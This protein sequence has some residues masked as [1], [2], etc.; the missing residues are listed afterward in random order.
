MFRRLGRAAGI[1]I[2]LAATLAACD[3]S[4]PP[5]PASCQSS[6]VA[7]E[8]A[9]AAAPGPVRLAGGTPISTCVARARTD[10]QL[11]QVGSLLSVT[12]DQLAAR[13]VTD[14]AAALELGY[15]VGATRRGADRTNGV[16]SQLRQRIETAAA[17][18]DAG[19]APLAA[20]HRG[21]GAGQ[22]SG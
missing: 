17:L 19:P 14:P 7:L 1:A 9:L 18:R 11:Q 20:L 13:A 3:Q 10:A 16:A 4:T 21:I 15:L 8:Q 2:G 5:L 22:S 12:A 6:R